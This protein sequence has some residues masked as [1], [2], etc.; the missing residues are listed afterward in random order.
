MHYGAVTKIDVIN[1]NVDRSEHNLHVST[2]GLD[3]WS[4]TGVF[5][6]Y[7][8]F[9]LF[10]HRDY[11]TEIHLFEAFKQQNDFMQ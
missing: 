2:S 3:I 7:S 4:G 9:M 6:T 5:E 1:S 8:S 10:A 11:T